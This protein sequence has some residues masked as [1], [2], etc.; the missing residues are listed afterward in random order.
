MHSQKA[1]EEAIDEFNS[2]ST[3]L[4][5][6]SPMT[7]SKTARGGIF[8]I[9]H[10]ERF[11]SSYHYSNLFGE[12]IDA[13]VNPPSQKYDTQNCFKPSDGP[14]FDQPP[15]RRHLN[16]RQ[17]STPASQINH[18]RLSLIDCSGLYESLLLNNLFLRVF[19]RLFS[20]CGR[21]Q[22]TANRVATA[23]HR[24]LAKPRRPDLKGRMGVASSCS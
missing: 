2:L 12:Q 6:A 17:M 14:Y 3:P 7:G 22:L 18:L 20:A 15:P 5:S 21:P 11:S 4:Q 23:T 19:T 10:S 16:L 24:L 13:L 9:A 1:P 8:A